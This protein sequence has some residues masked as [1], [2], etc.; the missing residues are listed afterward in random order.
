MT[1]KT[2]KYQFIV[3]S[4]DNSEVYIALDTD[5]PTTKTKVVD[6]QSHSKDFEWLGN[7]AT[8]WGTIVDLEAG[9]VT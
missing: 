1:P 7:R 6:F 5:D 9:K 8:Q 2:G 3:S 4:D